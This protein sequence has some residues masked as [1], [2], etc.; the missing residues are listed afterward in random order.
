[1]TPVKRQDEK[2]NKIGQSLDDYRKAIK[3]V[4]FYRYGFKVINGENVPIE[5]ENDAFM[6]KHLLDG[7]HLDPEA[8]KMYGEFV[9]SELMKG[10]EVL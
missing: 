10:D 2:Q 7:V 9:V 5:L 8:H 6:K 4:A 3:E 1:V